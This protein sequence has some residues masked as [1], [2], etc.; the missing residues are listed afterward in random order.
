MNRPLHDGDCRYQ[1][2]VTGG[3]SRTSKGCAW[4]SADWSAELR[5]I[6]GHIGRENGPS[7]TRRPV[8]P[9]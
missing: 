3:P 7:I 5:L 1:S 4:P 6:L 2:S 8:A 9:E